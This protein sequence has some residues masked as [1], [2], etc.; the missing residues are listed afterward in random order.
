MTSDGSIC[1]LPLQRRG[2]RAT[3][4]RSDQFTPIPLS[5]AKTVRLQGCR[6]E[7]R[8][9]KKFLVIYRDELDPLRVCPKSN[10]RTTSANSRVAVLGRRR[11]PDAHEL[12]GQ[13][14]TGNSV[15]C[16]GR[17][18]GNVSGNE[19]AEPIRAPFQNRSQV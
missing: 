18:K 17:H 5:L 3:A 8:P 14:Q 1:H 4:E 11:D 9:I 19:S 7:F 15:L 16:T 12:G 6:S 13:I 10:I 2:S